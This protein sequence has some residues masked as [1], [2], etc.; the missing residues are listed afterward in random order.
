MPGARLGKVVLGPAPKRLTGGPVTELINQNP[1]VGRPD[2]TTD[3]VG[4][5]Q[6]GCVIVPTVGAA[7]ADPGAGKIVCG[8]EAAEAHPPAGVTVNEYVFGARLLIV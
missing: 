1:E 4:V 8:V 7:G 2:S 5:V 6:L 3:P